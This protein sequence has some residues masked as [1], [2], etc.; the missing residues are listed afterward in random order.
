MIRTR[1][2]SPAS[3][4]RSRW[5]RPSAAP[6]AP[7]QAAHAGRE[8]T[9]R[10]SSDNTHNP[11]ASQAYSWMNPPLRLDRCS[12]KCPRV[13]RFRLLQPT[14][15]S[16]THERRQAMWPKDL[17]TAVFHSATTPPVRRDVS[18]QVA[19]PFD[20]QPSDLR[21]SDRRPARQGLMPPCETGRRS[22]FPPIVAVVAGHGPSPIPPQRAYRKSVARG[23]NLGWANDSECHRASPDPRWAFG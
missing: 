4:A 10:R 8:E 17:S 14:M 16:R 23:H 2:L 11:K 1:I 12:D 13:I 9:R 21:Q 3:A 5:P 19:T 7:A 20:R 15:L 18:R 22:L 6:V